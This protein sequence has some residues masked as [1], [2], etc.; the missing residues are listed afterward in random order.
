MFP[1]N[2]R[3]DFFTVRVVEHSI[4]CL[5]KLWNLRPWRYLKPYS[6]M[7]SGQP[8]LADLAVNRGWTKWSPEVFS[9]LIYAG[10]VYWWHTYV[11]K[12]IT[13]EWII[14]IFQHIWRIWSCLSLRT[15]STFCPGATMH[16]WGELGR[17]ACPSAVSSLGRNQEVSLGQATSDMGGLV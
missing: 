13:A 16:S 1:L 8:V 4:D 7:C 12:N 14:I 15:G 2:V 6:W 17:S 9:N 10:T 3:K 11:H 5:E